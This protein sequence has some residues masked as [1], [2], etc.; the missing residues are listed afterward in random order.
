MAEL[1]MTELFQRL[2]SKTATQ[3]ERDLYMQKYASEEERKL[4]KTYF[5]FTPEEQ[6]DYDIAEENAKSAESN[7]YY[8]NDG[9]GYN[10]PIC[11]NKG[12]IVVKQP[13]GS[14]K[15]YR[16]CRCL[17]IRKTL[18]QVKNS[19]LGD[20]FKKCTLNTFDCKHQWQGLLK[21]KALEF[22]QSSSNCFFVGGSSGAGKSHICTAITGQFL[23]QGKTV[24]YKKWLD[25]VDELN[26]TR[27]RQ[28]ER[29]EEALRN[30]SEC[31]VLY[32]DDFLKG[33]NA[34][35][36]SSADIKL[37]Y[38][39]IDARYT[40]SRADKNK[41]Y[42]TIISSEWTLGNI[43][44]FDEATSGRIIELAQGFI[45]HLEGRDKNYR[46]FSCM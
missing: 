35:K 31:E 27:F 21:D 36:P 2:A 42:V 41:R 1:S 45:I 11:K 15:A 10:C 39:I 40:M 6:L 25:I 37:A 5:E 3:A 34:V 22:L 13:N 24:N 19:G 23:K 16:D 12:Y 29:Y 30:I 4:D 44:G 17:N 38:R 46:K 20:I 9:T 18:R 14:G 33:D 43:D 7:E 32:I 8:N 28:V 26:N